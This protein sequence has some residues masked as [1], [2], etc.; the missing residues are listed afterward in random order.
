MH[1]VLATP[2][3][4]TS[5]LLHSHTWHRPCDAF[6]VHTNAPR[7][8]EESAIKCAALLFFSQCYTHTLTDAAL[9]S[10]HCRLRYL[11]RSRHAHG[12][13]PHNAMLSRGI[14]AAACL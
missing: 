14:M 9:P 6:M 1:K 8:A 3:T 7:D 10:M 13:Q 12:V 11:T 2:R 4:P 5:S